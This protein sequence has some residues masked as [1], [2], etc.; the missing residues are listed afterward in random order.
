MLSGVL[1]SSCFIGEMFIYSHCSGIQLLIKAIMSDRN[2][3]Q[4]T[5]AEALGVTTV[6]VSK[7]LRDNSDIS[8]QMK[9][10]VKEMAEKL[11]YHPNILAQSLSRKH[12]RMI[13]VIVPE[14]TTSFFAEVIE[15]FYKRAR[16]FGYEIIL[17][18][19]H[20]NEEDQNAN[21]SYLHRLGVDGILMSVTWQT[22]TADFL[23]PYENRKLPIVFFDRTVEG[24]H[25]SSI[26][27]DDIKGA[28]QVI[29]YLAESYKKKIA[30][31]GP[32]E[33]PSVV[34]ARYLGYME[35]LVR[36]HIVFDQNR[37]IRCR[38]NPE[39][40]YHRF[41]RS[42]ESGLDIDSVFCAN[43]IIAM[44]AFRAI[45][46]LGLQSEITLAGFGNISETFFLPVPFITVAQPANEM[47]QKAVDLLLDEINDQ[48][49][50]P[51]HIQLGTQ[52]IVR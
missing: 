13:G 14:I 34:K 37:V 47:G 19:S 20:E 7:A 41:K 15:G 45:A 31:L 36:H 50:R 22:T 43:D 17:M 46:E 5:I 18:V 8:S 27:I 1:K 23:K 40:A 11:G 9:A 32:L 4:K 6:T 26:T 42:L 28:Q 12:T 33:K 44:S 48:K 2:I 49:E 21:L 3:T 35:A 24:T 25:F 39:D 30:Y 29:D 16:E 52:L 38:Y 51:A 10:R